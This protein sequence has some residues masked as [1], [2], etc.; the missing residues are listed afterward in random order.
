MVAQNRKARFEYHVLESIEVGIALR[1]TEVK[2]IRA[3]KVNLQ[4]AYAE[5]SNGH[6]LLQHMHISP[7]EKGNIFNHDPLRTRVL[8][9]HRKEIAK[10]EVKTAEKG[11][12]LIPLEVYFLGS[13][14]K[15]LLGVC[16]GKKLYDKRQS[17]KERETNRDMHRIND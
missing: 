10:L 5:V 14:V 1:G 15:I 6:L 12:T 17:I 9:A 8:L 4:E 2:A 7:F 3:G 11:L 16:K 13:H